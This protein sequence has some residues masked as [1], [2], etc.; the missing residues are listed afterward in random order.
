MK[1]GV[2]M[3][4]AAVGT[5]AAVYGLAWAN[6]ILFLILYP[7]G[8]I[9]AVAVTAAAAFGLDTLRRL[10][11]R[12]WGISLS[13]FVSIIYL[14]PMLCAVIMWIVYL[15]LMNKGYFTGLFAGLGDFLITLSYSITAGAILVFGMIWFAVFETVKKIKKIHK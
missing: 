6:L 15:A 7:F 10:F 9:L 14:P 8:V 4:L 13:V 5:L 3:F 1:K 12:R 2:A 11:K